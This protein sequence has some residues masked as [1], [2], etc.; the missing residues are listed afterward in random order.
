[1][2]RILTAH[3]ARPNV[4]HPAGELYLSRAKITRDVLFQLGNR[5]VDDVAF[6]AM[7]ARSGIPLSPRRERPCRRAL[8][9]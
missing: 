3:S 2:V 7:N 6:G 5:I 4:R 1:M 9:D 8:V